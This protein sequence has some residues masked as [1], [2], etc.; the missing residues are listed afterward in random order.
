ADLRRP[1]V[2][3]MLGI[4][5]EIGLEQ[6]LSGRATLEDCLVESEIDGLF[7]LPAGSAVNPSSRLLSTARLSAL[8]GE[9]EQAHR[10]RMVVYDLP[11]VLLGDSCA[12]FLKAAGG[13]LMVVEEG[14]T[15]KAHLRRALSLIREEKLIGVTLNK[16]SQRLVEQYG[17]ISYDYYTDGE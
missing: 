10:D 9:I 1:N 3:N 11:P 15:T 14:R 17:Y 13:A 4:E 2:A 6:V 16:A 8:A 12:P 5:P 7:I